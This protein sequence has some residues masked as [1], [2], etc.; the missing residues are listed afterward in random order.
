MYV[1]RSRALISPSLTGKTHIDMRSRKGMS[2]DGSTKDGKAKESELCCAVLR[3]SY[4]ARAKVTLRSFTSLPVG[5]NRV[6]IHCGIA[7]AQS[8]W[9]PVWPQS[10]GIR[11]CRISE[12]GSMTLIFKRAGVSLFR[13]GCT[14]DTTNCISSQLQSCKVNPYFG[15]CLCIC[16]QILTTQWTGLL[17]FSTKK[18]SDPNK[19]S[20]LIAWLSEAPFVFKNTNYSY[21]NI[22][23]QAI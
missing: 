17:S 20:V 12:I 2:W 21:L 5:R 11:L 9:Y 4:M 22:W 15:A 10:E 8:A 6:F 14:I 3:I 7:L 19:R 23:N 1:Q 18:A 16:Q 13:L